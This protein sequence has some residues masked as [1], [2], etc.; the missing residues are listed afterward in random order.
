MMCLLYDD[1][2]ASFFQAAYS[3]IAAAESACEKGIKYSVK[4]IVLK[5]G[6]TLDMDSC[7]NMGDDSSTAA[8]KRED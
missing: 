4:Y 2:R 7:N 1:E 5:C 3:S 8:R 6:G